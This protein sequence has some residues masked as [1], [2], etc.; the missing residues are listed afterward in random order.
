MSVRFATPLSAFG[1]VAIVAVGLVVGMQLGELTSA[2][3]EQTLA[4]DRPSTVAARDV[5]LRS[6]AGF[7]GFETGA[8]R[9]DVTRTGAI[10]TP[11]ADTIIVDSG[12]ATAEFRFTSPTRL[13]RIQPSSSPLRPGDVVVIRLNADGAGEASLRV[14]GDLREGDSR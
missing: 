3:N 9:G 1:L 14:P 10:T 6:S 13:Y 5:G 2:A 11:S 7:N 8:L 12:A 4:L